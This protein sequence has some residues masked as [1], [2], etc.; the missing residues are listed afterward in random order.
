MTALAFDSNI[1]IDW[2][3]GVAAADK[4]L[5]SASARV[6]S[7]L[8]WVE[9]LAGTRNTDEEAT[10]RAFL[11]AGFHVLPVD[12]AVAERALILRRTRRMKLADAIIHA[13]ALEQGLQLCT[14]NTK[15]FSPG[16]PTIRVP[17]QL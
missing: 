11:R 10:A 5:E 1:L 8:T 4:E 15:D 12:E 9:V 16:D 6:I 2:I 14:R 7:V 17:Y 3:N 13:T